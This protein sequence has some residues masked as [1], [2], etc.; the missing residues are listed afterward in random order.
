MG[1]RLVSK[2]VNLNDL[3]RRID[4]YFALC[5]RIRQLSCMANYVKVVDQLSTDFLRRNAN[6]IKYTKCARRTLCSSRQRS[7][8]NFCCASKKGIDIGVQSFVAATAVYTVDARS[9]NCHDDR[10]TLKIHQ[11]FM[12]KLFVLCRPYAPVV[13]RS[14][15]F[16]SAVIRNFVSNQS[17]N[18]LF[19]SDHQDPQKT[20]H[21]NRNTLTNVKTMEQA[22]IHPGLETQQSQYDSANK[23]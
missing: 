12:T 6:V 10:L 2:S 13:C 19:V 3:Q 23:L 17:I 15:E 4:R 9:Y 22:Y 14:G 5:R 1:F 16:R 20:T 21:K 18:H 11:T 8:L 7:L